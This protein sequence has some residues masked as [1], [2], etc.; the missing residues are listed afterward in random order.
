M[1]LN[2]SGKPLYGRSKRKTPIHCALTNEPK[3]RSI[4]LSP[5]PGVHES[6]PQC[7]QSEPP[8]AKQARKKM[9]YEYPSEDENGSGTS[10]ST[11]CPQVIIA[12]RVDT[13]D[14]N[15]DTWLEW[16][17]DVPPEATRVKIEGI[18]GSFSTLFLLRIPI[19]TWLLLPDD[20][21]YSFIGFV[22]TDNLAPALQNS[23]SS[24]VNMQESHG[25]GQS[26]EKARKSTSSDLTG[27]GVP[28]SPAGAI[29]ENN[30][31]IKKSSVPKTSPINND[32]TANKMQETKRRDGLQGGSQVP[33]GNSESKGASPEEK[34]N[35]PSAISTW[36]L[37]PMQYGST[38]RLWTCV[39]FSWLEWFK[40]N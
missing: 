12:I 5:L 22:T 27:F 16:I 13:E 37:D 17:K 26:R 36:P 29:G 24:A 28:I 20:E 23:A 1:R 30:N 4:F 3:R 10:E 40:W 19:T 6:L 21:A 33:H 25:T 7:V 31:E 18:Y 15:L 32:S 11:E 35:T 39:R 2:S 38:K 34:R 8:L 14:F 9:R